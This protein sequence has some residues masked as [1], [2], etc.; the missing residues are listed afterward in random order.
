MTIYIHKLAEDKWAI[1][2]DE[3]FDISDMDAPGMFYP[4]QAGATRAARR[5]YG[6]SA[7]LRPDATKLQV[8]LDHVAT[9]G[10]LV[11]L[12]AIVEV[13]RH[14]PHFSMEERKELA[15]EAELAL[16]CSYDW[17]DDTIITDD[18]VDRLEEAIYSESEEDVAAQ[19]H[20]TQ[21]R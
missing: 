3:A 20:A 7:A 1:G 11:T 21:T 15:L 4:S 10:P 2:P 8:S 17:G 5:L 19:Q 16:K 9:A 6:P 12:R 18:Q 14:S 13:L